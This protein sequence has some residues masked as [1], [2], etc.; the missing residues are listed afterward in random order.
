MLRCLLWSFIVFSSLFVAVKSQS[1]PTG[2]PQTFFP[3]N[4]P[5]AIRSPYFSAWHVSTNGSSQLTQSWPTFWTPAAPILG[6]AG[7]IRVDGNTFSWLGD[8][9]AAPTNISNVTSTQ[10]TPTRTIFTMQAGPMNVTVTFISPIEPSDWA[11]QSFPFSYVSLDASSTDGN[12]HDVQVYSDISAE[13]VSGNRS[14]LVSWSTQVTD[15]SIYHQVQKQSPSPMTEISSQAEDG[16]AYYAMA[17]RPGLTYQTDLDVVCRPQ[18]TSTG[19]LTGEE[20][21]A[22]A[23]ISPH[24]T[25]YALSVDLGVIQSTSSSVVWGVGFVRNPSIQYTTSTGGTQQRSPY[26]VSQYGTISEAIDAFL[27]DYPAAL[28]RAIALDQ[29]ILQDAS[30]ISSNYAELVSL[31][32]RQV[33]GATDLTI[34]NGTDGQWNTSDVK[35]FMKA[36]GDSGRVNPVETLYASFPMFLYLNASFGK[37]LLSGLLEFQEGHSQNPYAAADLGLN[38]PVASGNTGAHSQGVE[39]TGNMLIMVW[40]HART[41]GDGSLIHDHYNLLK[42]WAN[43]L[44][45]NS[46]T[47]V[48]QMTADN[49]GT[50]NMTNLAIKGIIAVQA[51]SEISQAFGESAVAQMYSSRAAVLAS[52]WQSLALSSDQQHLLEDYGNQQSSALMYNL[53]ADRLLQLNLV[54]ETVYQ[55]QTQFYASQISTAAK[56]GLPIDSDAPSQ[57][58]SAWTLFTAAT[59]SNTTVLTELISSAWARAASNL[60]AGAFPTT[61]QVNTGLTNGG[62]ASPAQGAMFAP[63]A[64]SVPNTTVVVSQ[65]QATNTPPRCWGVALLVLVGLAA[66]L[67]RR[68]S[69]NK[70]SFTDKGTFDPPFQNQPIPYQYTPANLPTETTSGSISTQNVNFEQPPP[71]A[72]IVPSKMRERELNMPQPHVEN[73]TPSASVSGPRTTSSRYTESS[74]PA[75][76][77]DPLSPSSSQALSPTEVI[78]LRTEV[79][80]LRRV[81][82]EIRAE[83]LEPPPGYID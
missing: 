61:Y 80:N 43:Y 66:F 50:A 70:A 29:K 62:V 18:F 32:A 56:Y 44:V 39:Q 16:T 57:G 13:W 65:S 1:N 77:R 53:Y 76:S 26:Y 11:K 4:I 82:Q 30:A 19:V 21:V 64:L 49:Q 51:M 60:S 12:S 54:N 58:N 24:F 9:G 42:G 83:R 52:T 27:S 5:L 7:K 36:I 63:L 78:G 25:V 8:D 47:P 34:S 46:L 45:Q 37:P 14:S 28:Q 68:R 59:A 10:I 75:S 74:G 17:S 6:W 79:E 67:F 35:M 31:A 72:V 23:S 3:A 81:M 15:S 55:H 33:I 71:I 2:S 69:R 20:S 40:A 22:F 73:P 38:Y 48:N 41:T